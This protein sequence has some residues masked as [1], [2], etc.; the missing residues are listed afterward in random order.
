MR[1]ALIALSI[2]VCADAVLGTLD[3]SKDKWDKPKEECTVTK[4]TYETV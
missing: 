4:H 1:V 3:W 2:V